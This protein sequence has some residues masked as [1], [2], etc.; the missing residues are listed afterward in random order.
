MNN[1]LIVSF[2]ILFSSFGWGSEKQD[3]SN[4]FTWGEEFRYCN[5][6]KVEDPELYSKDWFMSVKDKYGTELGIAQKAFKVISDGKIQRDEWR[7]IADVVGSAYGIGPIGTMILGYGPS[8]PSTESLI[9]EAV[10]KIQLA[11]DKSEGRIIDTMYDIEIDRDG[12][13]TR[14][15][16]NDFNDWSYNETVFD[17]LSDHKVNELIL[18]KSNLNEIFEN[19]YSGYYDGEHIKNMHGSI[20]LALSYMF[21]IEEYSRISKFVTYPEYFMDFNELPSSFKSN[22]AIYSDSDFSLWKKSIDD[23]IVREINGRWVSIA[24]RVLDYL[25]YLDVNNK[26]M[27]EVLKFSST[28][29]YIRSSGKDLYGPSWVLKDE[30]SVRHY[31]VVFANKMIK[32]YNMSA[33]IREDGQFHYN[34]YYPEE[35]SVVERWHDCWLYQYG[36]YVHK[37]FGSEYKIRQLAIIDNNTNYSRLRLFYSDD[38]GNTFEDY[39]SIVSWINNLEYERL[40]DRVYRPIYDTTKSWRD[41]IAIESPSYS[42]PIM[43]VDHDLM[44]PVS[45]V[46][47]TRIISKFYKLKNNEPFSS[48]IMPGQ[49]QVFYNLP[50]NRS[51]K[52]VVE[53]DNLSSIKVGSIDCEEATSGEVRENMLRYG[54]KLFEESGV[55]FIPK[56]SSKQCF[57][58]YL[59]GDTVDQVDYKISGYSQDTL[60][61][62]PTVKVSNYPK[63]IWAGDRADGNIFCREKGFSYM[64]NHTLACGDDESAYAK[65]D[66]KLKKWIFKETPSMN[67]CYP[68]FGSI[69]CN[70]DN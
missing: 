66:Y 34:G 4:C 70:M 13:L 21:V 27:D 26:W 53:S 5:I 12:S 55:Y 23:Q 20:Q 24:K 62:A 58:V 33:C 42:W 9:N 67:M 17:K 40:L 59:S 65:Y 35:N 47:Y 39:K 49:I 31:D 22:H 15:F 51:V 29:G 18:M 8:A 68:I 50:E 56:S 41:S 36:Y 30:Q 54:I 43:K 19:R 61:N 16:Y 64:A 10:R 2:I 28:S 37:V 69:G 57:S 6:V 32:K 14:Q 44:E 45:S 63:E 48:K 38:F 7:Y 46:W 60:F 25:S 11:I 52:L 1:Y 3:I